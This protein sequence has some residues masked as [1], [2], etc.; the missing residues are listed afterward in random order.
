L[1]M[2]TSID[3]LYLQNL[4]LLGIKIGDNFIWSSPPLSTFTSMS[5][6]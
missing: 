6:V 5:S 4:L 1:Q 3:N 2:N